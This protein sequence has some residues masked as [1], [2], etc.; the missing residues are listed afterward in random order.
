VKT[1]G[2][3]FANDF[4]RKK[5]FRASA[6]C[7]LYLSEDTFETY[8]RNIPEMKSMNSKILFNVAILNSFENT[9]V[10][11]TLKKF[12]ILNDMHAVKKVVRTNG[13]KG[14]VEINEFEYC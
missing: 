7:G 4:E 13:F 2:D 12:T 3:L 8:V 11:G 5:F 14:L 1:I 9:F 6:L 10:S